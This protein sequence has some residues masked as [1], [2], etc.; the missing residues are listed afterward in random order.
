MGLKAGPLVS[1]SNATNSHNCVVCLWKSKGKLACVFHN[2]LMCLNLNPNP[3]PI[4]V[5][6]LA[7]S[8]CSLGQFILCVNYRLWLIE[9]TKCL[10]QDT[11]KG[12]CFSLCTG[13]PHQPFSGISGKI[14]M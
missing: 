3:N 4:R 12:G 13:C 8:Y 7:K 11:I 2:R 9:E 14:I 5:Q 1:I 6:V 10:T